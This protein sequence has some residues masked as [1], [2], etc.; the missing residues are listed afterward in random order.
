MARL[1]TRY[2]IAFGA[3]VLLAATFFDVL[4]EDGRCV[5]RRGSCCFLS[6]GKG[7]QLHAS[8]EEECEAHRIGPGTVI[9]MALDNVIDGIET[10]VSYL[11]DPL[12]GFVVTLA[13]VLHEI[14]QGIASVI[15]AR[16]ANGPSCRTIAVLGLADA[17]YPKGALVAG[18][19]P[20]SC[21]HPPWRLSPVTFCISAR[22]ISYLKH[23]VALM[24]LS[25]FPCWWVWGLCCFY[26]PFSP[27]YESLT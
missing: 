23:T 15:I 25:F 20:Q 26:G 17:L 21:L 14:P 11:I 16:D 1:Q 19:I 4:H 13:V 12:M 8:G 18:W 2:I 22:A 3:G 7:R 24:R 5:A 9:G 27:L 10:T 6:A